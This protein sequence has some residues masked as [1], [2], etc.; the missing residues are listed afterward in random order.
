MRKKNQGFGNH[1][2]V[3]IE[4]P[5]I[6]RGALIG[7]IV[8]GNRGWCEVP[9]KGPV[10]GRLEKLP[11]QGIRQRSVFFFVTRLQ[12][13]SR[14]RK[15]T[16]NCW[17][18]TLRLLTFTADNPPLRPGAAKI[19][20][21]CLNGHAPVQGRL[22]ILPIGGGW[23]G[24]CHGNLWPVNFTN[25]QTTENFHPRQLPPHDLKNLPK[26]W[27]AQS[28]SPRN[29]SAQNASLQGADQRPPVC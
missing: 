8:A 18:T 9:G 24:F 15:A 5:S 22:I 23:G 21:I 19:T 28:E 1:E 4:M 7:T 3:F 27:T 16:A 29:W 12:G 25:S 6:H 20:A 10:A 26:P 11:G 13:S 14:E 17:Q 2:A